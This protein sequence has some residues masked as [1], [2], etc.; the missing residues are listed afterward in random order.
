MTAASSALDLGH[1]ATDHLNG[2]KAI[3][4]RSIRAFFVTPPSI[5]QI[6]AQTTY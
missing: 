4:S 6:L 3:P 2:V 1:A 5:Y